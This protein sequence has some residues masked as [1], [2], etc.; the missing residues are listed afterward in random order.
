MIDV[1]S[2]AETLTQVI[3]VEF[4]A[5]KFDGFINNNDIVRV[6]KGKWS[7]GGTFDATELWNETTNSKVKRK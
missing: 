6:I 2:T 1:Q 7:K 5:Q 3:P 4:R